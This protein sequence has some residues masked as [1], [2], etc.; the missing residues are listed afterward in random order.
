MGNT[1][2][3][4]RYA[5]A[6]Q[7]LRQL[8]QLYDAGGHSNGRS[9]ESWLLESANELLGPS[10]HYNQFADSSRH[11]FSEMVREELHILR[12]EKMAEHDQEMGIQP[13]T[14]GERE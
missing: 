10:T 8:W 1:A 3:N 4:R 13:T 12:M 9:L 14:G 5:I 6:R 2:D 7:C 11:E